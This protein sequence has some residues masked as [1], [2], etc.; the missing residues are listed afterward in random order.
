M[1]A[2]LRRAERARGRDDGRDGRRELAGFLRVRELGFFDL[3]PF[4]DME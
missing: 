2:G 1:V 4:F 3:D